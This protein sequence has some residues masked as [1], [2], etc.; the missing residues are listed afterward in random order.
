MLAEDLAVNSRSNGGQ[1]IQRVPQ[2]GTMEEWYSQQAVRECAKYGGQRRAQR[3]LFAAG[4]ASRAAG[5]ARVLSGMPGAG[6]RL[7]PRSPPRHAPVSPREPDPSHLDAPGGAKR[8]RTGGAPKKHSS[9]QMTPADQA[10]PPSPADRGGNGPAWTLSP[11]RRKARSW[12][13]KRHVRGHTPS[14]PPKCQHG[15]PG[16]AETYAG[17]LN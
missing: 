9:E 1:N 5:A 13:Q 8:W 16:A 7:A 17:K 6:D 3:Q 4:P 12:Q 14:A 10:A 2:V 11:R 15:T